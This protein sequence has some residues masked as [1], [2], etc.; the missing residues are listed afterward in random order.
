MGLRSY[1]TI[2]SLL[3]VV[4]RVGSPL[5][6]GEAWEPRWKVKRSSIL[7]THW[8][9]AMYWKTAPVFKSGDLYEHMLVIR[10][11]K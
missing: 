2:T 11:T 8:D 9:S 7:E 3:R 1:T 5:K 6:C 10:N 4:P